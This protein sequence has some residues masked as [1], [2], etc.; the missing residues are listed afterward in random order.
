MLAGRVEVYNEERQVD[1]NI[2]QTV[3][4]PESGTVPQW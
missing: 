4:E 1:V 2:L 3:Q